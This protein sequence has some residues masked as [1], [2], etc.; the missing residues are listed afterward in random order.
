MPPA[1]DARGKRADG[2]EHQETGRRQGR[3][4]AGPAGGEETTRG[5]PRAHPGQREHDERGDQPRPRRRWRSTGPRAVA[6]D[7][8]RRPSPQG[9]QAGEAGVEEQ[10]EAGDV[11]GAGKP[12]APGRNRAA[13]TRGSPMAAVSPT[14]ASSP[15][16]TARR[17][18]AV[19]GPPPGR[20]AASGTARHRWWSRSRGRERTPEVPGEGAPVVVGDQEGDEVRGAATC[21]YEGRGHGLALPDD[22]ARI[23]RWCRGAGPRRGPRRLANAPAAT[24]GTPGQLGQ[25]RPAAAPPSRQGHRRPSTPAAQ[26]AVAIQTYRPICV[27]PGDD[28][29]RQRQPCDPA[30]P[31]ATSPR[32]AS[33]RTGEGHREPHRRS[34]EGAEHPLGDHEATEGP[35]DRPQ[36][37]RKGME[38]YEREETS[39][40]P[41]ARPATSR[42]RSALATMVGE[43]KAYSQFGGLERADGDVCGEWHARRSGSGPHSGR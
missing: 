29:Q 38:P 25:H 3:S 2:D 9:R 8:P 40:H 31:A 14:R 11:P 36:R 15:K 19:Q 32:R 41:G 34:D 26:I 35:H 39:R 6:A 21:R 13:E 33:S 20:A 1:W 18:F 37:R 10:L 22:L 30:R 42:P 5:Q 17:R 16:H 43:P 4:L 7:E 28:G 27:L 24:A 12:P 23:P